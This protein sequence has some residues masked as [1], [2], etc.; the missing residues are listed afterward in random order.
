MKF[1]ER[2]EQKPTCLGQT[3]AETNMIFT[4]PP[5]LNNLEKQYIDCYYYKQMEKFLVL[6]LW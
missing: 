3:N 1:M 2:H 6:V 5:H 4:M